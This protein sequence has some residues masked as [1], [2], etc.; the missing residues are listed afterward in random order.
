MLRQIKHNTITIKEA[1][2]KKPAELAGKHVVGE[3][4]EKDDIPELSQIYH[5]LI[6]N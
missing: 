2:T 4:V 5:G 6:T 1:E 3:F